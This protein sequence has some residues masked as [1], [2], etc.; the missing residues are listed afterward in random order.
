MRLGI[1]L[2]KMATQLRG[3]LKGGSVPMRY[4]LYMALK[5]TLSTYMNKL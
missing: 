1:L 4:T 5:F 2:K 3:Q